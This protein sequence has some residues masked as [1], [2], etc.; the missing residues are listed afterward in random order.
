MQGSLSKILK[1]AG[2]EDSVIIR[3]EDDGDAVTFVFENQGKRE[4]SWDR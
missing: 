3:A 4:R 1:C 2:N